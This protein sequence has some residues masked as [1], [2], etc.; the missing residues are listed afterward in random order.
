MRLDAYQL[1]DGTV[2]Q[3]DATAV[4]GLPVIDF[5]LKGG[6]IVQA[7]RV[8]GLPAYRAIAERAWDGDQW[9][10]E[11][12]LSW[13]VLREPEGLHDGNSFPWAVYTDDGINVDGTL[14]FGGA[15]ANGEFCDGFDDFDEACR[16]ADQRAALADEQGF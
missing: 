14:R 6:Q 11:W 16:W 7:A 15:Y 4:K 10:N 1:P 5:T 3:V 13:V 2:V 12:R 8:A 9:G